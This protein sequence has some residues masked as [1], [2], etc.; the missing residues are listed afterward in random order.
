MR[1]HNKH[2]NMNKRN[3]WAVGYNWGGKISQLDRFIKEKI[4]EEGYLS[5]GDKRYESLI[6]QIQIGDVLL[7][8]TSSTKGANHN[9]T[10]TRLT[11]IG[12][13]VSKISNSI[14]SV[15]WKMLPNGIDFDW[16]SYRST[17]EMMRD[18]AMKDYAM[19]ESGKMIETKNMEFNKQ[20]LE[21]NHNLILTGAPGTGKTYLAKEIAKA[22]GCNDDEIGFVQFHPSY[23]Y[24]DFVEGLRPIQDNSGSVGF[25]RKDG[26]FKEF[27]KKAMSITKS[28]FDEVYS[29]F[30]EDIAKNGLTLNTLIYKKDFKVIFKDDNL[31]A[32]PNTELGT[33]Q[34]IE[35]EK[36]LNHLK[37]NEDTSSYIPAIAEYIKNNYDIQIEE[38]Q[39][40]NK[41]YVFIIDEINRG[42]ISKIFGEL[43]FSI[44]PGYRG[45]DENGKPKGLVKTQYQNLVDED[46][47]F[48][49]GFFVPENVYIIG[50]MNDIDRSVE[51]MDFAFRRRFAF[52]EIKADENIGMLDNLDASVKEKAI[53]RMKNLNNAISQ[54]EGLSSAYHI[55]ASYFLK[56]KNYDNDFGQLWDYHIEGLLREY[57][58]GYPNIED[59]LNKLKSAYDNE[60][61]DDSSD[62][63]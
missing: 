59:S 51:S 25:E 19:I 45:V 44:D 33:H 1:C 53:N 8:K 54:V 58:R 40:I 56:L 26:V 35:K 16:I 9:I 41:N 47:E 61:Q 55:G 63:N 22:M 32:V 2:T 28:N 29:K 46:D 17:I 10:F 11:A 3:F 52:K 7:A 20:L 49:E 6:N 57:L 13:V 30:I 5:A 12:I 39:N 48:H 50:T 60:N 38:Q 42:E 18:D 4:W 15:D 36:I 62:N 24:T 34:F 14:F 43:F 27:C 23:D 21:S 31:F 37:N